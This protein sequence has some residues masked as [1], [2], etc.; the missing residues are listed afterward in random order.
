MWFSFIFGGFLLA[1]YLLQAYSVV[2]GRDAF[3]G[4]QGLPG[5]PG[6]TGGLGGRQFNGTGGY[7]GS[8]F[9]IEN[10][11]GEY[12]RPLEPSPYSVLFSPISFV[13]LVAGIAFIINGYVL[14]ELT[15]KRKVDKAK[16]DVYS[17]ILTGDELAVYNCLSKEG[18]ELTQKELSRATGF[19]PVRTHRV[20]HR[21][22]SK[23]VLSIVPFG[24]TN[25]IILT[26]TGKT[27]GLERGKLNSES[28]ETPPAN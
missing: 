9:M 24:M 15:T 13:F 16:H 27:A 2:W 21:L 11:S 19:S 3:P 26:I 28:E 12:R 17:T 18:G 1:L 4:I 8:V 14:W 7:N 25:K 22:K 5:M 6:N 10:L 23:G 20:L